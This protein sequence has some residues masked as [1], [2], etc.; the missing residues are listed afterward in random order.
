VTSSSTGRRHRRRALTLVWACVVSGA[1][2]RGPGPDAIAAGE[3]VATA[4]P[5]PDPST[6]RR[7]SESE[8]RSDADDHGG[9]LDAFDAAMRLGDA[10]LYSGRYEAARVQYL[11]A[12]DQRVDS[13]APALGALRAMIIDGQAEARTAISERIRKKVERLL[14]IDET[15]GSGWLLASRLALAMGDPGKAIDAAHLAVE[16]LP[17]MG[18]AWRVLGEAALAAEHWGEAVGALQTAIT[19]G[20]EAEAGTWERLA[21]GLDELAELDAAED[22]ARTALGMTGSDPHARRR[23][24]NLL[25]VILKHRGNL[26]DALAAAEQARGFGP[27]D[28]SVLHN[29]ATIAEARGKPEEAAVLYAQA[30]AETPVPMTLWRQGR[31][32][33]E[34]DRPDEALAAFKRAAANVAR[35]AWPASSRWLP[36]YEVGKLYARAEHC[37]EAIGWFDDALREARTAEATREIRSWLGYCRVLAETGRAPDD[38]ERR[39]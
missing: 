27:N 12:M 8:G 21:D 33:L 16:E 30:V 26:E 38:G 17:D 7:P 34:L 11:I 19:L 13:M 25:A 22:A 15:R 36:A 3:G 37:A 4:A 5:L 31:L 32:L 39:R 29:L 10:E 35:W 23:R 6:N 20:L 1:C 18:V 9:D 2:G 28:P 24:L 14:T